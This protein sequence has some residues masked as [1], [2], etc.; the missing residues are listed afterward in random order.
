VFSTSAAGTAFAA[1]E[2][3][4]LHGKNRRRVMALALI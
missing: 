4:R 1:A 3:R 2:Q